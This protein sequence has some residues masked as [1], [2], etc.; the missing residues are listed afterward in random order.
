MISIV[1]ITLQLSACG[2]QLR[3]SQIEVLS[4]PPI[5]VEMDAKSISPFIGQ[6]LK[7][8]LE[9]HG[10]VNLDKVTISLVKASFKKRVI[11][12]DDNARPAEQ[13]LILQLEYNLSSKEQIPKSETLSTE[14]NYF[15]NSLSPISADQYEVELKKR[16]LNQAVDQINYRL[17]IYLRD[18]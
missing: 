14:V 1:L 13:V 15:F 5:V 6:R 2:F 4:Q 11:S 16:L 12:L 18:Q 17:Q 7:N 8:Q 10:D 9:Q 3:G